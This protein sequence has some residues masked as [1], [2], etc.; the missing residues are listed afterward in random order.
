MYTK[1]EGIPPSY[2]N[3][4][5]YLGCRIGDKDIFE[6]RN[7][8]LKRQQVPMRQKTFPFLF[9]AYIHHRL[10]TNSYYNIIISH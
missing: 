1:K 4:L 9:F 7:D 8:F 10:L 2:K 3:N 5:A 6:K